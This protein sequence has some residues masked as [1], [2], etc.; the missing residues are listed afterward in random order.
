MPAT[1]KLQGTAKE[2][3]L[4]MKIELLHKVSMS[5]PNGVYE[6]HVCRH[7]FLRAVRV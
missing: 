1:D 4:T 2:E 3:I 5:A 7:A 6:R